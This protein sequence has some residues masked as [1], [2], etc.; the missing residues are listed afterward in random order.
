MLAALLDTPHIQDDLATLVF[1]K[2]EGVPFFLEELVTSLRETGVIE[3]HA[4]QWQLA[5]ARTAVPVPNTV[6]EVL[7]ARIDRLPE[8]AKHVLQI[9]AVIGRECDG[10][11]LREV[12]KLPEHELSAY[13]A[14]ITSAELLYVRSALQPVTYLFKHALT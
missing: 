10:E 12:A 3:Q 8:G 11:L 14:A 13:L 6:E 1:V 4:G 2:V 7:M 9:G 5:A